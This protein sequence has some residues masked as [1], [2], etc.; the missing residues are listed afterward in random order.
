MTS[1]TDINVDWADLGDDDDQPQQRHSGMDRGQNDPDVDPAAALAALGPRGG[2]SE[3]PAQVASF[4]GLSERPA[5]HE[6]ATPPSVAQ[7][8]SAVLEAVEAAV[9]AERAERSLIAEQA[10]AQRAE[11]A[12]VRAAVA[13]GKTVKLSTT[14]GRAWGDEQRHL[15]AV[16][17]GH[18]ERARRVRGQYDEIA[19]Q[20]GA[21]WAARIIE[22]LPNGKA[23]ALAALAASGDHVE[24]L[25]AAASA[26]QAMILEP[27]GSVVSLPTVEVSQF[28]QA[29][30]AL[31]E[32]VEASEPLAGVGLCHPAMSPTWAERQQQAASLLHGVVDSRAYWLADLERRE[33]YRLSAFTRGVPLPKPPETT[34]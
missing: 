8:W 11:T 3:A 4:D 12:R 14:P 31:A 2:T 32:L 16:A 29:A 28:V 19:L 20:Q 30:Q 24:R 27:G 26:A 23:A 18:R 1:R 21:T 22:D 7:A 9:D 25:L 17:A 34:W 6:A 15:E 5:W 33:G 13:S 10:Q